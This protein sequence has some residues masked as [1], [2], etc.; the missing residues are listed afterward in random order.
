[1]A[2]GR[3]TAGEQAAWEQLEAQLRT[4]SRQRPYS[5]RRPGSVP[6]LLLT[7][8][9]LCAALMLILLGVVGPSGGLAWA[10]V[11]AWVAAFVTVSILLGHGG[12]PYDRARYGGALHR[13]A[14]YDE[15]PHGG[16]VRRR[17]FG[18]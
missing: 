17:T 2:G 15:H 6:L 1:M 12:A 18:G 8:L 10:G 9:L 11:A 14:P 16:V 3:L 7:A 5:A 13:S 4:P